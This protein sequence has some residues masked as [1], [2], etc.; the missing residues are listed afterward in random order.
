VNAADFAAAGIEFRPLQLAA[1][2]GLRPLAD[3]RR[4]LPRFEIVHAHGARAAFWV[5]LAASTLG[6]QRPRIVYSIHGFTLPFDPPWRRLAMRAT[7]GVL[8][9]VTHRY[10]AVCDAERDAVVSAGMCS[11]ERIDV[12]RNGV[13]PR[14]FNAAPDRDGIRTQLG[15][16]A[17][18]ILVTTICRLARPRDF[19]T[20]LAGFAAAANSEPRA[21]LLIVGDGPWKGMIEHEVKKLGLTGRTTFTGTR[22]DVASILSA[23][24]IFVLTSSGGD[25]LPLG[26]LEAMAAGLPVVATACDGIPEAV[27]HEETGWLVDRGDARGLAAALQHLLHNPQLRCRLGTAGRAL[28]S[29]EFD[30]RRTVAELTRVY[31]RLVARPS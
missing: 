18:M 23:S 1:G 7:E 12:V 5:R 11:R 28:V 9:L 17:E 29:R 8:R 13:D 4:L 26:I 20:L 16:A 6:A 15:I 27:K 19:H 31:E 30:V 24:D 14:R 22:S 21:H 10:V 3:M 2:G 25:G